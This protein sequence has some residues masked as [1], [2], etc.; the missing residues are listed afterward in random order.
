MGPDGK[1][2]S[3]LV[4]GPEMLA[5]RAADL[6][7]RQAAYQVKKA[8][9]DADREEARRMWRAT[10]MLAGGSHNINSGNR[11]MYNR[12]AMMDDENR[13]RALLYMSP[14]GQA[15]A[16]VDAR[17]AELSGRMAQQAMTAFLANNPGADPEAR[18]RAE[19][20]ML[21]EKNPGMAG[22]QDIANGNFASTEAMKEY[23]R[24]A[25]AADTSP[26]G[27]S[28]DN[29]RALAETLQQ[30][31]YNMPQAEAEAKAYEYAEKRRWVTG[32]GPVGGRTPLPMDGAPPEGYAEGPTTSL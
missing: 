7:G 1:P 11:G 9:M 10:A 31:P 21:R 3:V 30:E 5:K 4:P 29:E 6:E 25:E 16:A 32:G 19:D 23:A 13:E 12:L 22:A 15:A 2:V 14:G 24:L 8:G 20:L 26:E 17:N 18:K 27:F 28:Y